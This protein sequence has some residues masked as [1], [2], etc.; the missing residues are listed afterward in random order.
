MRKMIAALALAAMAAMTPAHGDEDVFTTGPVFEEF[1]PVAGADADFVVPEGT[2]FK[3]IYDASEGAA[4][5]E[6]NP[7][8]V[9]LAR[10]MNMHARAG[11]PVENIHLVITLHG[12]AMFDVAK[13]ARYAQAKGQE[14]ANPNE[15][16]VAAL[17]G[18]GARVIV[19]GQ[20]SAMRDLAKE[21][22]LP[23]VELALSAMTVHAVL[24][25][26]G[27]TLNPF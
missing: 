25:A 18:K 24:Q 10:F 20:S 9:T 27:Y 2:V 3:V 5:G 17:I 11:V 21:D 15:A 1:G 19:C 7:M 12:P 26:E 13:Q 4:A 14:A 6:L 16:L 22:L 23:G 8:L